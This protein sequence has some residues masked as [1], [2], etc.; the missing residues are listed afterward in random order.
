MYKQGLIIP[1]ST[2]CGFDRSV[3]L[4]ID[5]FDWFR[6]DFFH[7]PPSLVPKG[8][9]CFRIDLAGSQPSAGSFR[10]LGVWLAK[11]GGAQ[12]AK[13]DVFLLSR[14]AQ[15]FVRDGSGSPKDPF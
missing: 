7:F 3:C 15:L 5:G 14:A 11:W 10:F 9:L 13:G 1:G 2:F 6:W 12:Q 8:H 4:E